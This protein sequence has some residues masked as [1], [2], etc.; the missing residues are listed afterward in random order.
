MSKSPRSFETLRFN[1]VWQGKRTTVRVPAFLVRLHSL[2]TGFDTQEQ[3][4]DDLRCHL[5]IMDERNED[6]DLTASQS[7]IDYMSWNVEDSLFL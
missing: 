3:A 1:A 6:R 7:C 2:V 4:F 5:K